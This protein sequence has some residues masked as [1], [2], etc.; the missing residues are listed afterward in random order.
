MIQKSFFNVIR[1][2]IFFIL[3]TLFTLP[4]AHVASIQNISLG[5]FSIITMFMMKKEDLKSLLN[6]KFFLIAY[7]LVLILAIISIKY[8]INSMETIDE[9]RG[10][11]I[12]PFFVFCF[13]YIYISK[14][15]TKQVYYIFTIMFS[16][17]LFHTLLN[18]LVWIYNG[19]WPARTGGFLDG[20]I[21]TTMRSAERFG[22]YATYSL[23]MS[24]ALFFTKYKKIASFFLIL[25][26]ISIIANNTRATFI[27]MGFIFMAYFIFIY[28]NKLM[29]F[30]AIAFILIAII[31][32]IFYSK[33]LHTRFN[34]YNMLTQTQYIV[35]YSPSEYGK[36]IKE[37]RLGSSAVA[38]LAMWKSALLYRKK[39]PFTPLGYGRFLYRKTIQKLWKNTPQ[40]IPF[41]LF[42]QLHS[43]FMS[44][45]FSLG[46]FGLLAFLAILGYFFK[47][48]FYIYKK[49]K[50][51]KPIGVFLFLG[52]SGHIASMLFGSFFGDSEQTYFY[53]L[54]GFTLALYSK[55][56][57]VQNEK[58]LPSSSK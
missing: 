36:L 2:N 21:G 22:I 12:K 46:L 19:G 17:L 1:I 29:K 41:L 53:I 18:I 16:A 31:S 43:D 28:K 50:E 33:N 37:H 10:E 5:I 20:T 44:M 32:F 7:L 42:P 38:R 4:V 24:I 11:I 25:S 58:T 47:I 57:N 6:F 56:K 49:S 8:S 52:L 54:Y 3:I 51:Y 55:M 35:K 13:I 9:I 40:N 30:S 45:F 23:A 14:L 15:S 26:L 34:A 27:G 39:D 48:S